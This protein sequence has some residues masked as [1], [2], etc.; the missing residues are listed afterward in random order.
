LLIEEPV[1]IAAA[2]FRVPQVTNSPLYLKRQALLPYSFWRSFPT[3][4][5]PTDARTVA[6]GQTKSK[7]KAAS[8]TENRKTFSLARGLFL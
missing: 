6:A 7:A 1:W 4:A 2:I 3:E 5:D 8:E